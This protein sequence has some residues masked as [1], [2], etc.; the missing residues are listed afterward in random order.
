MQIVLD[1][2]AGFGRRCESDR[3]AYYLALGTGHWALGAGM[4]RRVSRPYFSSCR[5]RELGLVDAC[6]LGQ[7]VGKPNNVH[8]FHC[9]SS[10]PVVRPSP[11][12]SIALPP[13]PA[14]SVLYVPARGAQ[15]ARVR[16]V[17]VEADPTSWRAACGNLHEC[18]AGSAVPLACEAQKY[19]T[20]ARP[21]PALRLG[22]HTG[23]PIEDGPRGHGGDPANARGGAAIE[24]FKLMGFERARAGSD[25]SATA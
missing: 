11:A 6:F 18:P 13:S 19:A 1:F 24:V 4:T 21:T 2:C 3:A 20:R 12:R 15:H 10:P 8:F 16:V 17:E 9:M 23:Q 22:G 5:E 14:H 7:H 25:V